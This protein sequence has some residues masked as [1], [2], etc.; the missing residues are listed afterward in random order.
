MLIKKQKEVSG[1]DADV[2]YDPSNVDFAELLASKFSNHMAMDWYTKN[3]LWIYW[4]RGDDEEVHTNEECFNLEDDNLFGGD[5]IA[6]IFRI[7]ID[8]FNF[9]TPLC[10]VF[11]EFNYLLKFSTDLLIN[12]IPGFKTYEEI[13]MIGSMNGIREYRGMD[14]LS[15]R[16]VTGEKDGY[17]NQ[18]DLLGMIRDGNTIYYQDYE[19]YEGLEDSDIKE[20]ACWEL[21]ASEVTTVSFG[22]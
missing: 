2:D 19:W 10:K 16:L 3:A 13:R 5:E 15:G 20:E 22:S 21:K 6:E 17:Y 9:K 12:D 11:Y 14:I 18:G 1:L 4:T 8:M 7:E